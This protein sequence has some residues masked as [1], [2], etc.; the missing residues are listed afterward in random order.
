MGAARRL[1]VSTVEVLP[2]LG[3]DST[4]AKDTVVLIAK[5]KVAYQTCRDIG[6]EVSITRFFFCRIKS[7]LAGLAE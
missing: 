2:Q 5:G 4:G 7:T 3:N 6:R 1:L